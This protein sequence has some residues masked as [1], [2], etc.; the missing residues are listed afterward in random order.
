M[1]FCA[2]E[3]FG[4]CLQVPE[5]AWRPR[6][7]LNPCYRRESKHIPKRCNYKAAV[8]LQCPVRKRWKHKG[9]GGTCIVLV[10]RTPT[11]DSTRSIQWLSASLFRAGNAPE[12]HQI[13]HQARCSSSVDVRLKRSLNRPPRGPKQKLLIMLFALSSPNALKRFPSLMV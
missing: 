2:Y 6:R 1:P 13:K 3:N 12:I 5:K 10:L 11:E 4:G 9:S 8:A 7:D